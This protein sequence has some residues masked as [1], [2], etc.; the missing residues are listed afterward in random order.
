MAEG[1]GQAPGVVVDVAGLARAGVAGVVAVEGG[2]QGDAVL[3]VADVVGHAQVVLVPDVLEMRAIEGNLQPVERLVVAAQ[4]VQAVALD[5]A[6]AVLGGHVLVA[7]AGS[8]ADLAEAAGLQ[9]EVVQLL[10]GHGEAGE[11]G[12]QGTV[13]DIAE[14]WSVDQEASGLEFGVRGAQADVGDAQLGPLA[15]RLAITVRQGPV[16]AAADA[17]LAALQGDLV[18]GCDVEAEADTAL[19]VAR[20]VLEHRALDPGVALVDALGAA[21][22]LGNA[23]GEA[24]LHVFPRVEV[25]GGQGQ[26][27]SLEQPA[28]AGLAL[29]RFLHAGDALHLGGVAGIVRGRRGCLLVR[30]PA[31]RG[32]CHHG[33]SQRRA[34]HSLVSHH[35]IAPFIVVMAPVL[36]T[37]FAPVSPA[38]GRGGRIRRCERS[39]RIARSA[40]LEHGQEKQRNEVRV[41]PFF[42]TPVVSRPGRRRHQGWLATP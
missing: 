34:G 10:A 37:R 19:G 17:A 28:G 41:V 35:L 13:V 32:R 29:D 39:W 30:R 8:R 22:G 4:V 16:A 42:C 38:P 15:D 21:A 12:G 24:V 27:L 31:W 20:A 18:E 1:E 11:A 14:H 36:P 9:A 40:V 23:E 7:G 6:G 26:A 3:E 25:A 33:Q 2:A 5:L